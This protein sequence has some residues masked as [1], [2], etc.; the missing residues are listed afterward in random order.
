L[1]G[2]AVNDAGTVTR[3][4]G[5]V[6][7]AE[8]NELAACMLSLAELAL[9]PRPLRICNDPDRHPKPCDCGSRDD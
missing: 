5:S 1:G 3:R 8:A 4:R 7:L 2:V 6:L 9:R